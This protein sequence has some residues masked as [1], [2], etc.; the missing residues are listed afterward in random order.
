MLKIIK[1]INEQRRVATATLYREREAGRGGERVVC[2]R[3]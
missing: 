2:G 1:I 3:L